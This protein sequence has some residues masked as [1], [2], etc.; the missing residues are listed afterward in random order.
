M[1]ALRYS[2]F[3]AQLFLELADNL[4]SKNVL[5]HIRVAVDM[6]GCDIRMANQVELPQ[7]VIPGDA[8]GL[9]KAGF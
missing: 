8:C 1:R 2:Y 6:A 4:G 5:N 7:P 9:S 3:G